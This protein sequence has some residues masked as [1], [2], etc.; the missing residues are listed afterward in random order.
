L[1]ILIITKKNE[2]VK[3]REI[4]PILERG[5]NRENEGK[6]FEEIDEVGGKYMAF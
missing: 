4:F 3:Y 5:L 6:L 1:S 2:K